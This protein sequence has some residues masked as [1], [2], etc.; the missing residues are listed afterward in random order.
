MRNVPQQVLLDGLELGV[1]TSELAVQFQQYELAS[2]VS[3]GF[4]SQFGHLPRQKLFVLLDLKPRQHLF[5]QY[6]VDLL[7]VLLSKN[8]PL[9]VQ[10]VV[11]LLDVLPFLLSTQRVF[12]L[13]ENIFKL[14]RE[15]CM[16]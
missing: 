2:L 9:A 10:S 15:L 5:V 4:L 12:G 3:Q 1:T 14:S 7:L 13:L 6:S 11:E 16:Q 8:V